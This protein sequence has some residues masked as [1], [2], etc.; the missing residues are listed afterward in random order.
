MDQPGHMAANE[1]PE[2]PETDGAT[3]DAGAGPARR[4]WLKPLIV[5]LLIAIPAGYLYISA[6]QSRGGGESKKEQAAAT[7]LEEG[8]PT[9]L[10]RRLYEV[11]VP[12]YAEHVAH[13]ETNAWKASSL[14]LQFTTTR[15]KFDAWL[16]DYA[17]SDA[18]L[19]DGEVT[20]D[21]DEA[22][23]VGWKFADGHHWAGTVREQERPKPNLEI[24]ANLDNPDFPQV[25]VVSTTTP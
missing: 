21:E 3:T 23:V 25:Y 18:E 14:Y 9:R 7:G 8:W 15:E 5:F 2:H 22:D 24:T 20:I 17:G 6:M 12:P 16:D 13:F 10:Q 1:P 19:K 11:S 4:R